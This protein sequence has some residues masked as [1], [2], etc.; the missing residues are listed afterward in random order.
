MEIPLI[1]HI[2]GGAIG[3]ASAT[4]ALFLRKGSKLHKQAGQVFVIAMVSMAIPGGFMAYMAGKPFDVLSSLMTCYMVLTGFTAFKS[5]ARYIPIGLMFVAGVC[6]TAYLSVELY[7]VFTNIRATDAPPGAGY[8]FATI[9][10]LAL[11]GDYNRFRQPY[12]PDQIKMRHVWRMNFGL[13]VA[14]VSFFGARPH[15]FPVWMQTSGLL[16]L[17][18]FAPILVLVYWRIKL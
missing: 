13:L 7:A 18:A 15:L 8:V 4:L 17:L 12:R 14:T 10:A 6:L 5:P 3:L 11:L 16:V 1:V 2:G 9:L